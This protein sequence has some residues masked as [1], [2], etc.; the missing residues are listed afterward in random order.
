ME[1][2]TLRRR[3]EFCWVFAVIIAYGRHRRHR[4]KP[5]TSANRSNI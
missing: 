2:L 1:F 4:Q 5:I 3:L